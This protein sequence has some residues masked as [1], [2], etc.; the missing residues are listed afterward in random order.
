M[1]RILF[2]VIGLT[3][4]CSSGFAQSAG[5]FKSYKTR[6]DYCRDNPKMPTCI[7]GRPIKNIDLGTVGIYKPP[8]GGSATSG[9]ARGT[10]RPQQHQQPAQARSAVEITLQD[11]RFSHQSPAMLIN[12]NIKSLLQSPIWTTLFSALA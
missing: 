11:W 2:A 7:D 5:G 10:A 4:R 9:A 1:I 12:I 8:T 3:L 6:E